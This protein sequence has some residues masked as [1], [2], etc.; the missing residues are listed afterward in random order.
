MHK[1]LL[2]NVED[3]LQHLIEGNALIDQEGHLM[4]LQSV[5]LSK[6]T[7]L[8]QSRTYTFEELNKMKLY[9]H[10][11]QTEIDRLKKL[12]EI[13]GDAMQVL[14]EKENNPSRKSYT[15]LSTEEKIELSDYATKNPKKSKLDIA[16][17]Y[18]ISLSNC[19]RI[20]DES[21]VRKLNKRV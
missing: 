4:F 5:S 9:T 10:P 1:E 21:G 2:E 15:V 3:K 6:D 14:I 7:S 19:G 17:L 18:G 11:L 8:N 16:T 13:Q 12:L 20:L